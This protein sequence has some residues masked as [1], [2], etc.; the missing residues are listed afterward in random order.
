MYTMYTN[1]FTH[2]QPT[3]T[4]PLQKHLHS[5]T[6]AETV[7]VTCTD[8]D[9]HFFTLFYNL[10]NVQ[11]YSHVYTYTFSHLQLPLCLRLHNHWYVFV[12]TFYLFCCTHL[13]H[14]THFTYLTHITL[15]AHILPTQ[16]T[17]LHIFI[18]THHLLSGLHSH[19]QT[20]T[21]TVTFTFSTFTHLTQFIHVH[22]HIFYIHICTC[23]DTDIITLTHCEKEL[24]TTFKT[25][26]ELKSSTFQPNPLFREHAC[27]PICTGLFADIGHVQ[28]FTIFSTHC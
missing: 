5:D 24:E 9:S 15:F 23:V 17:H 27:T 13:T 1:K 22:F 7:T 10:K 8:A 16:F 12:C 11:V 28:F 6:C 19:V 3:C 4:L 21:C 25:G 2:L 26:T 14:L 20:Y 18:S